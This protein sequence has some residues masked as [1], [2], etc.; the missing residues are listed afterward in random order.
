LNIIQ[1]LTP[2]ECNE[3]AFTIL[4]HELGIGPVMSP[5]ASISL[6]GVDSK[7]WLTYLEQICEVFRGEIPHVKHPKLDFDEL[8]QRTSQSADV[9]V[10]TGFSRLHKLA[11]KKAA[12]NLT[13]SGAGGS[14]LRKMSIEDDMLAR[15]P[16]K[17]NL[18]N[19]A[20][21]LKIKL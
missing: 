5:A 7:V 11:A 9:L 1:E 20:C 2:E 16:R 14:G 4:E 10:A 8:K 12:E 18:E 21:E 17:S 15:R 13:A 19:R 3:R 6:E